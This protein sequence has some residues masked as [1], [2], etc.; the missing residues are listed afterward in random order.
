MCWLFLLRHH[1]HGEGR[2]G[3]DVQLGAV[4]STGGSDRHR[5]TF[6]GVPSAFRDRSLNGLFSA[7]RG[8][9]SLRATILDRPEPVFAKPTERIG[10]GYSA[11]ALSALAVVVA[12]VVTLFGR[13]AGTGPIFGSEVFGRET[14][15]AS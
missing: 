12:L 9:F 14:S 3:V 2:G 4:C 6:P 1:A 15:D 10:F 5:G 7:S 8:L 11:L 13:F